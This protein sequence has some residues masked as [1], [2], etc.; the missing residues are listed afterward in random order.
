LAAADAIA[1]IGAAAAPA[2]PQLIESC[3]RPGEHVHVLRSLAK[4]L[5]NT[6]AAAAPAIP[7]LEKLQRIPRVE[8]PAREAITKIASKSSGQAR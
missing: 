5:G 3:N 6:G 2:V 8:W 1:T 4:A 7:V